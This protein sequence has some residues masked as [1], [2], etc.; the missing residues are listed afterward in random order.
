MA[1]T[2]E[3]RRLGE[4]IRMSEQGIELMRQNLRRRHP[5]ADEAQIEHL[6][7]EWCVDRPLDAPGTV[8]RH[9]G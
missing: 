4:A 2:A 3:A 8:T 1:E 7:A 6:L 5:E 9:T